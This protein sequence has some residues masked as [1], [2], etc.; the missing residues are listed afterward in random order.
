MSTASIVTG[1][2]LTLTGKSGTQ[3]TFTLYSGMPE[4]NSIGGVY[5]FTKAATVGGSH[6]VIYIGMTSDLSTRFDNHHKMPCI[7]KNGANFLGVLTINEE[8]RRRNAENDLLAAYTPTCN[9]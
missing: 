3:Y 6:T 1:Y 4:F 8:S 7:Q 2:S 5:V 9:G